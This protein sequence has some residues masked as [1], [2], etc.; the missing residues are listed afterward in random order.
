MNGDIAAFNAEYKK[1]SNYAYLINAGLEGSL[2]S[3][4]NI[5]FFDENGEVKTLKA[6]EKI[7]IDDKTGFD[8][9]NAFN[10]LSDNGSVKT[11]IFSYEVNSNNEITLIDRAEDKTASFPE[12]FEKT[13]FALNFKGEDLVFKKYLI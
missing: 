8:A 3:E 5:K 12:S 1:G 4:L 10:E 11:Q 9:I 2:D 6:A 13:Q 7:K